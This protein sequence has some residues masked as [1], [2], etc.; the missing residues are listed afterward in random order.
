MNH[1]RREQLPNEPYVQ[2]V[3]KRLQE[4][5]QA[6]QELEE[7]LAIVNALAWDHYTVYDVNPQTGNFRSVQVG[8]H[9]SP[10]WEWETGEEYSYEEIL[11]QY[12]EERILDEDKEDVWKLLSLG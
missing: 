7:Q 8:T 6:K 11:R 10:Q 3:L 9:R 4:A 2:E 1:D 5:E 12:L